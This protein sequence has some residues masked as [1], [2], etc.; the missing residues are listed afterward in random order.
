MFNKKRLIVFVT[1]LVAL[2][3]MT[4]YAGT[5]EQNATIATR[6]VK[7]IDG[8]NNAEISLQNV[9]VG[10]EAIVP[11]TPSHN[12]LLFLGWYNGDERIVDFKNVTNDITV[13]AKY[14]DDINNNLIADADETPY[15][16]TFYD[17]VNNSNIRVVNVLAGLTATAPTVPTHDGYILTGWSRSFSNVTSNITVNA[18]YR[19]V[20]LAENNEPEIVE[21]NVVM[22]EV[23]FI[24]GLT[25]Q[26][27]GTSMVEQGYTANP[28]EAP[29]LAKKVF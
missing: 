8:Y 17:T 26:L 24:N 14:A 1:F 12:G 22:Y 18:M 28:P 20:E 25:N 13:T 10:K 5:P 23:K 4:M 9:E 11:E 15:S 19:R 21:P 2:F 7:F 29:K 3:F 6:S 16:V 27:I